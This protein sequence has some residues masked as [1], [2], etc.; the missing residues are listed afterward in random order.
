MFSGVNGGGIGIVKEIDG[1]DMFY[2]L[3]NPNVVYRKKVK[4]RAVERAELALG[5]DRTG[6]MRKLERR[7][8][9]F[10]KT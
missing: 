3:F 5:D 8:V 7:R 2:T 4:R 6:L 1:D 9:I 10:A